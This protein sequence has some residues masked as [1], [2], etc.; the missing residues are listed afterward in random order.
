[1]KSLEIKATLFFLAFFF[2]SHLF[3]Q[4]LA[5]DTLS[6]Y[7][8]IVP[9]TT[10]NFDH[11]PTG[12][13]TQFYY[14]DEDG[15][16]QN[17]Y[18]FKVNSS[19]LNSGSFF[20]ISITALN[21]NYSILFGRLDNHTLYK[22]AKPL[23]L[24]DS[25]CAKHAVWDSTTLFLYDQ[26]FFMSTVST[27]Y[28]WDS[29]GADFIGIKY[30]TAVDTLYGWIGVHIT[31]AGIVIRDYSIGKPRQ[32]LSV[33]EFDLTNTRIYPNPATNSIYIGRNN[34]EAMDISLFDVLGKQI[35]TELKSNASTIEIDI[36]S[37]KAGIYFIRITSAKGV[38]TK[39]IAVNH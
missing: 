23:F 29:T 24:G 8:D 22:V 21:P 4:I 38:I 9:D 10:I 3:S 33:K 28:D 20:S 34:N 39:K 27:I 7:V 31:Y 18:L 1:M 25:I 26:V 5:G 17:D 11:S 13:P 14:L 32:I 30:Q 37:L 19:V 15:D 36:S 2:S 16:L 12:P 35:N 6:R